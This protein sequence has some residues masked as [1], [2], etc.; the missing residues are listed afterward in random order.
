MRKLMLSVALVAFAASSAIAA[1]M[2]L[3]APVYAPA[4][5]A[6]AYNWTG[7]YVGGTVGG[8]WGNFD[9]S[10]ATVFSPV[11]YFATTS[12]SAVNAVGQQTISPSRFTGGFE[13]GYN[14]QAGRYVF[15]IE[16]DIESFRL[17]GSSTTGPV[18]YP[19]CA[20]TSFTLNSN[21]STSWLATTRGRLGV[22]VDNWLFFGTGGVAFTNLN[23]NFSLSDTFATA[24][25]SASL[26]STKAGYAVGG[27]VEA[28]LWGR[29]TVKAEYLY[30]NF[31]TVST[32]SN[33]LTAFTPPIA[34]PANA[35]THSIDLKANIARLGLNYRF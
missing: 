35:F 13:A 24:A 25:E 11:G 23:G 26:S 3:K 21:A 20:P 14:W 16:S 7:F 28:G 19:C 2:P 18:L 34:F 10:T 6:P 32:T 12:V 9:P 33:N 1:D 5:F 8:A 4:P 17:S 15:G 31:G 30:V 27:G 22:A 29:W